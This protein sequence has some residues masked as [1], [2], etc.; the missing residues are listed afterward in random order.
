M[1]IGG[2]LLCNREDPM[3]LQNGGTSGRRK[4]FRESGVVCLGRAIILG[5]GVR[6][7][8]STRVA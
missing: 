2:R 1:I 7:P 4:I 6:G 8:F 3:A 5:D